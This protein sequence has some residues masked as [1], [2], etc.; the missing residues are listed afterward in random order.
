MVPLYIEAT[1]TIISD[2][3]YRFVHP[4]TG[5]V[6]GQTDYDDPTKLE[7]IG[8]KPL[9]YQPP[10]EGMMAEDWE[11]VPEGAGF[12]RR[13]ISEV[14]QPKLTLDELKAVK[15]KESKTRCAATLAESDWCYI[16]QLRNG[17]PV[18]ENIIAEGVQAYTLNAS[19]ETLINSQ[20]D[21]DELL[22]LV[23]GVTGDMA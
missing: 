5:E 19:E 16:R 1:K 21:Y 8:A 2:S 15:I 4:V 23:L 7:E 6:Y 22:A 12:V 20:T 10:A 3:N 13:P 14:A 11:V 18:P 9:R 17:T